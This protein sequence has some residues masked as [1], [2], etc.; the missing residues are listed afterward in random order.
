MAGSLR[1]ASALED[2][3]NAHPARGAHRDQPAR[4]ARVAGEHLR[5]R[6]DDARAGRGEGVPDRN[7]PALH[8]EAA[9]VDAAERTRPTERIAAV[10]G[11]LPRLQRAQHLGL[12][13]LVDLVILEVLELEVRI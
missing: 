13:G 10:L 11:C 2:G 12:E 6:A 1:V 7:A 4:R 5:E 9:A 3:G 8:V